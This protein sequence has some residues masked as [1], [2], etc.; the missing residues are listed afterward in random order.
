LPVELVF[1]E[2]FESREAAFVMEQQI[3]KWSRQKKEALIQGDFKLIA[4]FAKK[5]FK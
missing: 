3:K 4:K 1:N 2:L 5:R